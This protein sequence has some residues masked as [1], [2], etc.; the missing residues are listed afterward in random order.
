MCINK[1]NYELY[2][3]DYLEGKLD[4]GM[5]HQLMQFIEDNPDLAAELEGLEN[6]S[7]EPE[8]FSSS[9]NKDTLK[10]I[11][12]PVEDINEESIDE[13]LTAF[14]EGDMLENE[15]DSLEKFLQL[16]PSF[17]YDLELFQSTVSK[18]EES[19]IFPIKDKL[20]HRKALV[21]INL[22]Y[23]ITA[24][25]AIIILLLG[26][27][28]LL[29]DKQEVQDENLLVL[30]PTIPKR[31]EIVSPM[32]SIQITGIMQSS[33]NQ[34]IRPGINPLKTIASTYPITMEEMA[35][36]EINTDN[37]SSIV[38][39]AGPI[40]IEFFAHANE[41]GGDKSSRG[42]LGRIFRNYSNKA[43]GAQDIL[44]RNPEKKE[45][46]LSF[47]DIADIGVKGYNTIADRE[48]ELEVVRDKTGAPKEYSFSENERVLLSRDFNKQ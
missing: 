34:I 12:T 16:N 28:F 14:L 36:N 6:V 10:K 5:L 39:D 44:S 48:V 41:A 15:R 35:I 25:A 11:I 46:N 31:T 42:L 2:F 4:D 24:A 37:V 19:T 26:W 32:Q 21:L 30:N 3:L 27:R 47:W 20:R 43:K 40:T 38:A 1:D 33:T 18:P 45:R 29:L 23:V 8:P 7:L 13:K 9:L 22:R 17:Q